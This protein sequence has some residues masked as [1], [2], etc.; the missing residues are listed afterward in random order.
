VK[1]NL[2]CNLSGI[3]GCWFGL[4]LLQEKNIKRLK[5]MAQRRDA[6]FGGS[7]FQEIVALNVRAFIQATDSMNTAVCLTQKGGAHRRTK[8]MA[9]MKELATSMQNQQLHRFCEGRTWGYEASDDFEKGYSL[10]IKKIPEFISRTLKDAG[11]IHADGDVDPDMPDN[12]DD[13]PMPNMMLHG[14]L[15]AGDEIDLEDGDG[16]ARRTEDNI[17]KILFEDGEDNSDSDVSSDEDVEMN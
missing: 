16:E 14:S 7:F 15:M 9:A 12:S 2:L 3:E 11:A 1:N 4:D 6:D 5:K 13:A 10:L 8:K 17:M